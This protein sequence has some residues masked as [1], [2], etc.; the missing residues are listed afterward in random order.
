MTSNAVYPTTA[1]RQYEA[2]LE[3][4][5]QGDLGGPQAAEL[6]EH[7]KSCAGCR[8]ALDEA[9]LSARLLRV[10]EPSADPGPGFSHLVMA[11][12]RSELHLNEG[13]SV[14]QSFVS[15]AWRFAATAAFALV[16]LVSFDVAH[17]NQLQQDRS[18]MA[19]NKLPEL[20]PDRSSVPASA[21]E[22]LLMMAETDHGQH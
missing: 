12:I 16:L 9:V 6:A 14:W 22:V 8:A 4:H 15:L 13:K 10:A 17:H 2:A 1:C 11:R 21:D 5:L 20:V 7:L 3:D 19:T 18:L